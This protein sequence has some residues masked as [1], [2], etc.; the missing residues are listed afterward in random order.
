ML[1]SVN[2]LKNTTKELRLIVLMVYILVRHFLGGV[3]YVVKE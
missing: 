3:N 2:N 1:I